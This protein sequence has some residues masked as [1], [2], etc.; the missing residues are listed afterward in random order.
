MSAAPQ[1]TTLEEK[2]QE[3]S[4]ENGTAGSTKASSIEEASEPAHLPITSPVASVSVPPPTELTAEQQTK[5]DALLEDV[6]TWT[7]IPSTTGKGGSISD[8]EIFWL[9]RECLL[10]Y[11]RATKWNVPEASKR[12]L[13]TLTWRREYGVESL[14]GEHIS[15][16]NETGKQIILGYDI[17]AR[18]CHYL[19][20]GRQNTEA[21][22]RQVQHLVFMVERGID[23]MVP[24]QE[25]LALL[26]NFKKSE[27][28]SNTAPGIGQGREVL[29]I[30][31]THYPERLGRALIINI[32][33]IVNGFFKLITPFIDPM[34]RTKLKFND[35]MRQHVPPEQLWNEFHGDLAFDYE[36]DVY[37]PKLMDICQKKHDEQYERWVKAGK[38][39]GESEVYLRGGD[40][41]SNG[42]GKVEEPAAVVEEALVTDKGKES[43]E[44]PQ[45]GPV[46]APEKVGIEEP[47]AVSSI[48]A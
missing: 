42:Q 14:T 38:H 19:N 35:D 8:S 15:P 31:Q 37:W 36:H 28:R 29:N 44:T 2:L 3:I 17:A 45:D 13:A 9:T 1:Q 33:W 4:L 20:P 43:S 30:L 34:T 39:F 23:M 5:Y 11:L 47:V 6:K 25:T 22:P 21:S 7:E 48:V 26:I 16:E 27:K 12:L 10:R 40:A 18:P 46:E 41:A 32:P 24:G